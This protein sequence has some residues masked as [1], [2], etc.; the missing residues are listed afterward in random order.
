MMGKG[1]DLVRLFLNH[2]ADI[3][4]VTLMEELLGLGADATPS[5]ANGSTVL[6]HFFTNKHDAARTS[7]TLDTFLDS[8]EILALLIQADTDAKVKNCWGKRP[9]ETH[10]VGRRPYRNCIDTIQIPVNLAF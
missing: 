10:T 9:C 8:G 5:D 4:L 1:Y 7:I 2:D 3:T 6:H